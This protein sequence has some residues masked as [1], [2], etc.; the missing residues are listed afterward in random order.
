MATINEEIN[1]ELENKEVERVKLEV[2]D[3][4]TDGDTLAQEQSDKDFNESFEAPKPKKTKKVRTQ[5]QIEA[6][7]KARKKRAE[8]IALKKTQKETLKKEKKLKKTTINEK[9]SIIDTLPIETQEE[10]KVA[11]IDEE[12]SEE[13]IIQ[14][15]IQPT[16]PVLKYK[17][18]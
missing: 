5:K 17:F 8:N 14:G 4:S 3:V 10:L 16:H 18:V 7:E 13:E 2:S 6:F 15:G 12:Y 1:E 11:A 9:P